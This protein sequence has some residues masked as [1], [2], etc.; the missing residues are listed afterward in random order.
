MTAIFGGLFGL[1]TVTSIVA[2]LIQVVPV[3][4]ERALVAASLAGSA[5]APPKVAAAAPAV[6]KKER[7]PVPGPWR[8]TELS[9]DASV[10][11]VSDAIDRRSFITALAD[12]GV[13][14]AQVYRVMKAFDGVRKF[15]KCGRKDRFTVAMDRSTRRVRAFEYAISASEVY[16][17]REDAN[18]LLTGA[19]LD[20]KIAE[21]EVVASFYVGKD[22]IASYRSGGLE[23][24]ALDVI[25][26]ALSGRMS[27]ESFEEGGTVRLI[28]IEETALGMFSRYK[29]VVALEYRPPDPAAKPV[30]IYDFKG[31][32]SRGYFDERGRQPYAGGWRSPVPGA[33]V[34]SKFNPKRLHPVLKKIMPHNGTDFGAPMGTPVYSAYRGVVDSVGPAGPSGNLVTITHPNGITTGY[35]HLSRFAPGIKAGDRVGTHHLIGYVGSTGRSTGPHLHFTAKRD[36]K[37]F[38]AETLQLDGERVMPGTDRA[39]FSAAKEALDKRLDSIPLPEPPPEPV[40]PAPKEA[41]PA[42]AAPAADSAAVPPD[43]TPEDPG[44]D[45]AAPAAPPSGDPGGDDEEGGESIQG[46]DLKN[47]PPASSTP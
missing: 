15:D 20:M 22:I 2:L 31:Q 44:S 39:A 7:T 26:D 30:R 5:L 40:A 41:P 47:P 11:L 19:A 32:E 28:A 29:K 3:R 4:D 42:S 18:G 25:D 8:I 38:D 9:K 16:Q 6:K 34:T 24:G 46:A 35:A 21:E 13:P 10:I 36:G 23:D 12:K 27:T 17:A 14:K 45:P 33:P 43:P 1:A 37:F